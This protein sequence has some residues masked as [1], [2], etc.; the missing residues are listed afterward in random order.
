MLYVLERDASV[1]SMWGSGY[2]LYKLSG[3]LYYGTSVSSHCASVT[4][5]LRSI[6]PSSAFC[7]NRP[8]NMTLNSLHCILHRL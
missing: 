3:T 6:M 8:L 2:V 5:Y 1:N 4:I 7:V